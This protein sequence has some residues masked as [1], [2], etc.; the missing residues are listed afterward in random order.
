METAIH[1]NI[2][3]L[4]SKYGEIEALIDNHGPKVIGLSETHLQN[5]LPSIPGYTFYGDKTRSG[6]ASGTGIIIRDDHGMHKRLKLAGE[7]QED[8]RITAV[9]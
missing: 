9:K 6:H 4:E 7:R 2:C 5:E 3:G 1:V 8:E